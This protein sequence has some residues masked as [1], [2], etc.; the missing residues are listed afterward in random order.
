[1]KQQQGFFVLEFLVYLT[2]FTCIVAATFQLIVTTTLNLRNKKNELSR[3][4]NVLT[5]IDLI[6]NELAHCSPVFHQMNNDSLVWKSDK[7][8]KDLGI[9]IK[10]NRIIKNVGLFDLETSS[11]KTKKSYTLA[12]NIEK[13]TFEYVYD[14]SKEL[15]LIECSLE[16]GKDATRYSARKTIIV[17]SRIL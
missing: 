8:N 1:M 14:A 7:K 15:R 13:L 3:A 2:L 9:T 4:L 10:K 11:W 5:S 6:V 16:S 17:P 12:L